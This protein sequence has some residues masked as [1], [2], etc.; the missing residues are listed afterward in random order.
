M[1]NIFEKGCL[2]QLSISAWKATRKINPNF[3]QGIEASK[4]WLSATK[5]LIDPESLKPIIKAGNAARLYL[6]TISLPFPIHGMVFVPKDMIPTVDASLQELK[7]DFDA[8]VDDFVADYSWL[9]EKAQSHLGELFNELDY[10]VDVREKFSFV[11]RFVVLD[12]PNGR[13]GVLSPEVYE[14]EKEKFVNTMEEAR[15]LAI[16]SLREEFASMVSRICDRFS[17]SPDGKPKVFKNTTV[18]SFYDYFET[19]KQRNIFNDD[20]LAELVSRA[21]DILAG[22]SPDSIRTDDGLRESIRQD[23]S[24]V[25]KG[26]QDVITMPRRKI[27]ID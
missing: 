2:V 21:Q 22:A 7:A 26:L 12:V 13:A 4:E 9:R 24:E 3:L 15:L 17:A 20:S 8:T 27:I 19:F 14:R 1:E 11:W 23:M 6:R 10:P 5:K 18:N 25:E 16:K